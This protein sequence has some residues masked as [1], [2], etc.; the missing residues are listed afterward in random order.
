MSVKQAALQYDGVVKADVG[1]R[2]VHYHHVGVEDLSAQLQQAEHR[3]PV[4]F[5]KTKRQGKKGN[6]EKLTKSFNCF[7][8]TAALNTPPSPGHDFLKTTIQAHTC[9][10]ENCGF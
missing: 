6:L 1:E 4:K 9:K 5:Y 2:P 10:Q 3:T 8:S 7:N